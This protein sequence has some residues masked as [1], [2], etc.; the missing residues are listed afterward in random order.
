MRRM[1]AV[2]VWLL[3]CTA[4][5]LPLDGAPTGPDI[6]LLGGTREVRIVRDLMAGSP[7]ETDL[8]APSTRSG[9][10]HGV[11]LSPDGDTAIVLH[12]SDGSV[13][14]GVPTLD[15]AGLSV[16]TGLS[17]PGPYP[18]IVLTE[19]DGIELPRAV[20]F[21]P[22]GRTAVIVNEAILSDGSLT[23]QVIAGLPDAPYLAG[24]TPLLGPDGAPL[25]RGRPS[26]VVSPDCRHVAATGGHG[27]HMVLVRV[28]PGEPPA[29][30]QE[31]A[32]QV[33]SLFSTNGFLSFGPDGRTLLAADMG[34]TGGPGP[35]PP[36]RLYLFSG[37]RKGRLDLAW[38]EELPNDIDH[39]SSVAALPSGDRFLAAAQELRL[40]DRV[41]FFRGLEDLAPVREAA[42]TWVVH[43]DVM[44]IQVLPDGD[45][46]LVE[47]T[48]GLPEWK[49]FQGARGTSLVEIGEFGPVRVGFSDAEAVSIYLPPVMA[50]AGEDLWA[51]AGPDCLAEVSL[52]GV[53]AFDAL[54]APEP[55]ER[56]LDFSWWEGGA[57]LASGREATV[58]LGL[59]THEL[60]FRVVDTSSR[61]WEDTVAVVV[62]DVTPP[63][64]ERL[65]ASPSTLWP[66][67]HS[68]R[69]VEVLVEVRDNCDPSPV[70]ELLE[71]GSSEPADERGD[72][73]T[74]PDIAE[75]KPGTDDRA[76]LLRAERDGRGEGRTYRILY[77][78]TDFSGNA[79]EDATMVTVPHDQG[80]GR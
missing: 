59:G 8:L 50:D 12:R 68:F 2:V 24:E 36:A 45:T 21:L 28:I 52:Q 65:E 66:P 57:P 6:A 41:H 77:R 17:D 3:V 23:L 75:V 76:F 18:E 39:W 27:F 74:R 80:Y 70:I 10:L 13:R 49:V 20:E 5:G 69:P 7:R 15:S 14:N 9:S 72:G 19:D 63:A 37:I 25:E 55:D 79:A 48:S 62:E 73:H 31:D 54:C 53:A 32:Y 35:D 26:L 43:M 51:A 42:W 61:V 44:A 4:G 29:L 60:T 16:F 46:L 47:T 22:D 56:I 78:A 30:V 40:D 1:Q 11:A 58:R 64:F 38:T 34:T 33:S 67:D 71:V